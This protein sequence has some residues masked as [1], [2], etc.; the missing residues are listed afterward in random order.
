MEEKEKKKRASTAT[1]RKAQTW[2]IKTQRMMSF[3]IDLDLWEM[4]K[5]EKNK[6]GLINQLLREHYTEAEDLP[7]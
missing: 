5:N 1:I 2:G 6:G 4:M 3:K 7:L